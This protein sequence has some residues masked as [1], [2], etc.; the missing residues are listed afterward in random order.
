[1]KVRAVGPYREYI[2]TVDDDDHDT[3]TLIGWKVKE[4]GVWADADE[5]WVTLSKDRYDVILMGK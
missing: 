5:D 3:I 2:G 4:N 1:M